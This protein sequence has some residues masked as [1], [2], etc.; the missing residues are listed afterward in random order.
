MLTDATEPQNLSGLK[1]YYF[2]S[3]IS[4]IYFK[5]LPESESASCSFISDSLQPHGPHSPW[6]SPGQDTHRGPRLFLSLPTVCY[7][8]QITTD[9][10]RLIKTL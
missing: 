6:H 7:D 8:F 10:E 4:D 3:L 5:E 9:R 2:F 1:Q